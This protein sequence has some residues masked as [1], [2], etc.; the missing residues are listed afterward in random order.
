M[1]NSLTTYAKINKYGFIETPYRKVINGCVTDEFIYLS[2]VEEG[3][4]KIG[5]STLPLGEDGKILEDMVN[6][7]F[8]CDFIYVPPEEVDFI[9]I[10]PVQVVSIAA[11]LIPFL[12]NDDTSRALMGSNMQRQ[13]VPLI[14]NEAPYV[15]TGIEEIIA[16]DSGLN[17]IAKNDGKVDH[18]DGSS[19]VIHSSNDKDKHPLVEIYKLIKFQRSNHNTCINQRP[20]VNVGDKIKKGDIIA[21]GHSMD[22]GEI[23]LGKNVLVAF[24]AWR[25]YSF[26]DAIVISESVVQKDLFSS[27]HIEEFETVA[28]DTKLGSEEITRDIPNVYEETLS[29]L[30]ESGIINIGTNVKSGDILVGKVTP[31]NEVP[32]TPEEKLLRAIFGNKASDVSD[33][34]LYVPPGVSGTVVEVR[35]F[36]RRGVTKDQRTLVIEQQV[37]DNLIK[38]RENELKIINEFVFNYLKKILLGHTIITR[39]SKKEVID[40]NLLNTVPREQLWEF[41]VEDESVNLEIQDLR[42]YYDKTLGEISKRFANKIEKIQIGD[43]LPQGALKIVKIFVATKHKLQPGDKMA[44]RH[45]NKGVVAKIVPQEDMPFLEDGTVIDVI[46]NPLSLPARMNI[47]QVLETHLGWASVGLGKKISKLIDSLDR[48]INVFDIRNFVKKIYKDSKVGKQLDELSDDD[49]LILCKG[50][51]SGVYFSS[52]VFDGAKISDIK[53]MLELAGLDKS[54]QVNLIDGRT[55]E[56][57]DRPITVG[58]KYLLKLHHLVDDKVHARSIGPYSLVT[59]QPLGGKSHFGGQR[60]GEMECW[61]LEA[62]GAA[63]TLLEMLTVKSDDVMGRIKIYESIVSGD[64]SFEHG[65]PESFNVMIKELKSLCLNVSLQRY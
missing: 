14:R 4:Y 51:C 53:E 10:N 15:G 52:P 50:M 22:K 11:S 62:Y 58:Y 19:I 61:A 1:I 36:S 38:D 48:D 59:Q 3:K 57:F 25:G 39:G 63:Y 56:F 60:F 24:L 8:D 32:V 42:V 30:D 27:I 41:I 64:S 12:E 37:I 34:S 45:G 20:F 55:G 28:R 29:D 7:R 35:V 6:C 2:A 49:F 31:K 47:G 43:D 13:A 44:G 21:Q 33:S 54:G 65:I 16:R 9:D 26:E 23:A 46:L 5:Q 18:V 17:I 40:N